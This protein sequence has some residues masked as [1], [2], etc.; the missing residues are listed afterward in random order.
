MNLYH[1]KGREKS[2]KS[3]RQHVRAGV[4]WVEEQM[5][6]VLSSDI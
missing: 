4:G 1:S 5:F 3:A 2:H 6:K